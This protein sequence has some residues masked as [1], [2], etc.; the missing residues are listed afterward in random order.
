MLNNF[1]NHFYF[2]V[3][4]AISAIGLQAMEERDFKRY[5]E[6]LKQMLASG[7]FN[8]HRINE[9]HQKIYDKAKANLD[10]ASTKE[11]KNRLF[12]DFEKSFSDKH[13]IPM[14]NRKIRD[15]RELVWERF[16]VNLKMDEVVVENHPI[17]EK[18]SE[19]T[20]AQ[21]DKNKSCNL[22]ELNFLEQQY[23]HQYF[24]NL[25]KEKSIA[26]EGLAIEKKIFEIYG[27][28]S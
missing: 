12:L 17:Q 14:Q 27:Q 19:I 5:E 1:K 23:G 15:Y 24:E 6:E 22:A 28:K 26:E 10:K 11:G 8:S 7:N 16:K 3:V 20:Q 4:I 18:L 13:S 21:E 2:I 25:K 9:V